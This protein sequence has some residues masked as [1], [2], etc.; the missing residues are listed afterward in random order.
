MNATGGH[1]GDA[2]TTT[3]RPLRCGGVATWSTCPPY[4]SQG[5]DRWAQPQR[6]DD[7][8]SIP[9]GRATTLPK[10]PH[11]PGVER[12]GMDETRPRESSW[13]W[14]WSVVW[15][16]NW[17]KHSWCRLP[18]RRRCRRDPPPYRGRGGGGGDNEDDEEQTMR[19]M[20]KQTMRTMRKL[21]KKDNMDNG[22]NGDNEDIEESDSTGR[23]SQGRPNTG[24]RALG[25]GRV[26][27]RYPPTPTDTH[28]HPPTRG[29]RLQHH[30]RRARVQER[31]LALWP[32][33]TVDG[34]GRQRLLRPD[35]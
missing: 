26:P 13:R 12:V 25:G 3:C 18:R 21:K 33:D 4:R 20:R 9:P 11:L 29:A 24:I 31:R 23:R 17:D 5:S 22:D 2:W 30:H 15:G 7:P 8:G 6:C 35:R 19:T 28:R 34:S 14:G 10:H 16:E 1:H 32:G 27:R